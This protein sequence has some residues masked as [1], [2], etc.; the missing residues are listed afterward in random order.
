MRKLLTFLIA[1]L[2]SIVFAVVSPASAAV[3]DLGNNANFAQPNISIT[4]LAAVPA[5]NL[6]ICGIVDGNAGISGIS[7]QDSKT[8]T[9]HTAVAGTTQAFI[10]IWYSNITTPLT[11][12]D[13][14]QYNAPLAA[15]TLY[16]S[17]ANFG[18]T[19]SANDTATNA[20]FD[21]QFT[22]SYSLTSGTP[23]Q[24][25]KLFISLVV[26]TSAAT[27]N[28]GWTTS[29]PSTPTPGQFFLLYQV[30]A[31]TGTLNVSGAISGGGFAGAE[32]TSFKPSGG[33]GRTCGSGLLLHVGC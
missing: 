12:S 27:G 9:W 29:P 22:S 32:I 25:G 11:T 26:T 24:A 16:I 6:V 14:I 7:M 13:T 28:T 10:Q 19:Y 23:S 33:G 8:N 17:C 21:Q 3:V 30:N 20:N 5:G 31:G 18:T 1:A 4:S 2:A 15:S